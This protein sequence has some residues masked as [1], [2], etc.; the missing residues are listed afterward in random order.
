[1]CANVNKS[2]PLEITAGPPDPRLLQGLQIINSCC[3]NVSVL[4]DSGDVEA[5][6]S[7]KIRYDKVEDQVS[8][9][10]S[11]DDHE[12]L[13]PAETKKSSIYRFFRKLE[14]YYIACRVVTSE[15]VRL[16]RASDAE[17]NVAINITVE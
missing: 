5:I 4:G 3:D 17:R 13:D 10:V 1:M 16:V 9:Q 2:N 7:S 11:D 14:R 15:L 6:A 12:S 8:D